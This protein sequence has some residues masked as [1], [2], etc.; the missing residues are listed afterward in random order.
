MT[1][2]GR[3]VCEYN[4]KN[5]VIELRALNSKSLDLKLKLPAAY[6]S[7]EIEL[8]R[9]ASNEVERGKVDINIDIQYIDGTSSIVNQALFALYSRELQDLCKKNSLATNDILRSILMMP[10]I[11]LTDSDA[12]TD[13][14]WAVV[15]LGLTAALKDFNKFRCDEGAVLEQ[16]F[17][18]RI[19]LIKTY[20][21]DVP[22]FEQERI[23]RLRERF[24]RNV[25][26]WLNGQVK[27]FDENRLEQELLFYIEKLDVSEEKT[28][29]RQ[30][31]DY[32]L[33]ELDDSKTAAKGR[34][35]NF[36]SQ[37][38]GRE[39]NTI[40]SK[41]NHVELQRLVVMM[42]DELEKIKEQINNI[43]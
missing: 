10:N 5:I 35:L 20:L 36:I 7:Q 27:H 28:R 17:R 40:G 43:L 26:D 2:Y 6:R 24:E 38:I 21:D 3:A 13:E 15:S 19:G 42:K 8:R 33:Q 29:L 32:F 11:Y 31:C 34:K 14:E 23:T 37:E 16:E 39:I 1:G 4:G 25:Q 41:A 9:I 12:L 22:L 30:H 18:Q